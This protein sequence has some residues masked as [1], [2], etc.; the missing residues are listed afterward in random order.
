MDGLCQAVL[1][2]DER[3]KDQPVIHDLTRRAFAPS[4]AGDEQDLIDALWACGALTISLDG[5]EGW[6]ALGAISVEPELQRR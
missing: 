1:I 2:R 4:A 6:F 5:S 3:G